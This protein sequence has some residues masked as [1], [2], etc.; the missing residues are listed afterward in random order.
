M[1][2]PHDRSR[3]ST[4][5]IEPKSGVGFVILVAA[6]PLVLVALATLDPKVPV[7]ISQAVQAEFIGDGSAADMPTQT[8][9]PNMAEP[10]QTVRAY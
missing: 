8:A 7:W 4:Y 2:A 1:H 10:V 3:K 6:V 5:R 9:Q